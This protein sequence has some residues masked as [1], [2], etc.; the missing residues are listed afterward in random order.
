MIVAMSSTDLQLSTMAQMVASELGGLAAHHHTLTVWWWAPPVLPNGCLLPWG[1]E[2]Q[3]PPQLHVTMYDWVFI[4]AVFTTTI[5]AILAALL[6]LA[7]RLEPGFH[8]PSWRPEL[9]ARVDGWPV[10]ITRQHGLCWRARVDGPSTR[11]VETHARQ[12]GPSTQVV[13]TELKCNTM[14]LSFWLLLF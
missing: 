5:T 13:E 7:N 8:Y 12:L 3:G 14:Q 11:L 10:S 6:R 9:T 1:R 4:L 2:V